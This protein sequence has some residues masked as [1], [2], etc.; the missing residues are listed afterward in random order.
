MEGK[1]MFN[2]M[3]LSLEETLLGDTEDIIYEKVNIKNKIITALRK[4]LPDLK[5]IDGL[6][7]IKIVTNPNSDIIA[8]LQFQ[9]DASQRAMIQH[10]QDVEQHLRDVEQHM[11]DTEQLRNAN[12]LNNIATQIDTTNNTI[13]IGMPPI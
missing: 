6:D 4:K 12:N 9:N 8:Q 11:R 7:N 2:D 1:I 5:K 3:I 13:S 10:Q